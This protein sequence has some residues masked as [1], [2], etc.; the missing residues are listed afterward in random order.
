MS[1]GMNYQ[2][3]V[4]VG[5]SFCVGLMMQTGQFFPDLF[6]KT[7]EPMM[8]N[9]LVMGGLTAVL[10]SAAFQMVPKRRATLRLEPDPI[11]IGTLSKFIDTQSPVFAL[12]PSQTNSLQLAC[13]EVFMHMCRNPAEGKSVHEVRIRLIAEEDHL[14]IDM[15]DRSQAS[16]VDDP[17]KFQDLEKATE[18]ELDQLG[19]FILNKVVQE[20]THIRV[21]GYNCISFKIY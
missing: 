5:V 4:V 10:L 13:E 21:S 2:T 14:H 12:T 17:M 3:G 18:A 19:L 7:F 8:T 11:N 6:P 9:G 1:A 20:V 15:E 16:D